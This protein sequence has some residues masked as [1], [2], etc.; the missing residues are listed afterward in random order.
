MLNLS[1]APLIVIAVQV[2]EGDVII[3]D[4]Y[5]DMDENQSEGTSIHWHGILHH[6]KPY[7]DGVDMIT[8]CP[9]EF[10]QTFRYEFEATPP[11]THW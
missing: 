5:N 10:Q 6:K 9:I 11:G 2:C 1:S 4:V 8:Q 7:M 3:V